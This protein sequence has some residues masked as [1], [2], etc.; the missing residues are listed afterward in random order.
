M[1]D[2]MS[3]DFGWE[4]PAPSN[5]RESRH[6]KLLKIIDNQETVVKLG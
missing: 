6:Q 1:P 3:M 2:L 5:R 4:V